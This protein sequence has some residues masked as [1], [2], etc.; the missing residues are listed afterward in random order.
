MTAGFTR[1]DRVC[2][3]DVRREFGILPISVKMREN[4]LKWYGHVLRAREDTVRK[5]AMLLEVPGKR[6]KGRPKQRWLDTL[7]VDLKLT[8]VNPDQ[9]HD[10]QE[11][12]RRT[13]VADPAAQWDKR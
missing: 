6:P 8:S 9:A 7:R 1:L 12:R 2:N 11:W 3:S 10:R 5:I 4:R 13:N